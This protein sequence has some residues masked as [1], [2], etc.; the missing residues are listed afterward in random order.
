MIKFFTS[1]TNSDIINLFGV[2]ASLIVAIVGIGISVKTLRQNS[3]MLEAS[4]R[5][6]LQLYS[7]YSNGILYI[8][9]KNL[10]VSACVI[11]RITCSYIFTGKETGNKTMKGNIFEKVIG[12][13]MAPGFAI[14]CPLYGSKMQAYNL[15]FDISYH[16]TS[17]KYQE[18]F[19]LNILSNSAFGDI[20]PGTKTGTESLENIAKDLHDLVKT[21]L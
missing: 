19:S 9:I 20:Y 6:N 7:V 15:D 11:D 2:I 13:Q 18:H 8:I 16:S 5:P 4:T 10:G 3:K 12:A 1:L 17:K 21:K 14:R